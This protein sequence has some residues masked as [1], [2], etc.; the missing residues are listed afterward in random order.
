M[1]M[2]DDHDQGSGRWG[3]IPRYTPSLIEGV[4]REIMPLSV[5][6][7]TF[8]RDDWQHQFNKHTI[9][10]EEK[11][12]VKDRREYF[13]GREVVP[14]G[15]PRVPDMGEIYKFCEGTF[16]RAICATGTY[17]IYQF[18]DKVADYVIPFW[19][20][21]KLN[22]AGSGTTSKRHYDRAD[23]RME[24]E[25]LARKDGGRY[26]ILASEDFVETETAP[27]RWRG[28]Y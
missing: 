5:Y 25:K 9:K 18:A 26:V 3:Y 17:Q 1:G 19:M 10:W 11:S 6:Y 22:G 27:V 20:V 7:P 23:A 12:R 4:M 21:I 14:V 2:H 13:E 15:G 16:N 28:I 8:D 24:A